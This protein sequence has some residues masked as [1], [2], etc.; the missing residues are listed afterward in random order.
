MTPRAADAIG[1]CGFPY[2]RSLKDNG[3]GKPPAREPGSKLILYCKGIA[4][5]YLYT[6]IYIS[7]HSSDSISSHIYDLCFSL[8]LSF[9]FI[10]VFVSILLLKLIC[11]SISTGTIRGLCLRATS[12]HNRSFD[13]GSHEPTHEEQE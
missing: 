7:V 5:V 10:F 12:L 4:H 9:V 6:C 13:H 11:P 8:F 3:A 2:A 1:C